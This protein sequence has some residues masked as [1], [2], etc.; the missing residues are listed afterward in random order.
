M[1]PMNKEELKKYE[2]FRQYL[3]KKYDYKCYTNGCPLAKQFCY[4]FVSFGEMYRNTVNGRKHLME[5]VHKAIES[6]NYTLTD[7]RDD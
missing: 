5:A 6:E 2:L 1:N 3:C 4:V 7:G